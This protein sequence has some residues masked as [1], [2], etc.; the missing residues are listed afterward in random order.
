MATER[1]NVND[2][3]R[4]DIAE[5]PFMSEERAEMIVHYREV[6]GPYKS[7]KDLLKVTGINER[8]AERVAEYFD[9]NEDADGNETASGKS[10]GKSEEKSTSHRGSK[11][12]HT[13]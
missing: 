8:L 7:E 10:E 12:H 1:K 9:F 3:T 6:H 4:D 2:A 13:A 5:L 11:S